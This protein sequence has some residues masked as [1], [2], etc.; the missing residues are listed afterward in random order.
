MLN[1]ILDTLN[2]WVR[3]S[4]GLNEYSEKAKMIRVMGRA[5][6][7]ISQLRT[8]NERLRGGTSWVALLDH[9]KQGLENWSRKPHNKRWWRR[10]DGTPIPNDLCVEIAKEISQALTQ[11]ADGGGDEDG[12]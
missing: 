2:E 11:T 9:A 6:G 12:Q 4:E 7:E 5:A 3:I 10:I 1:D 8:D